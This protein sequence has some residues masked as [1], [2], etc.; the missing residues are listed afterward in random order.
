[1]CTK[2]ESKTILSLFRLGMNGIQ[3]GCTLCR[4][5]SDKVICLGEEQAFMIQL[6]I[7]D[8]LQWDIEDKKLHI[9]DEEFLNSSL[10]CDRRPVELSVLWDDQD[11]EAEIKDFI[12]SQQGIFK[13]WNKVCEPIVLTLAINSCNNVRDRDTLVHLCMN[14]Q[15]G[16]V[17]FRKIIM[18]I[19]NLLVVN[20]FD[21]NKQEYIAKFLQDFLEKLSDY[22]YRSDI[23]QNVES[24]SERLCDRI[25]G[26]NIDMLYREVKLQ[27]GDKKKR[28]EKEEDI[29]KYFAAL[30]GKDRIYFA[31]RLALI[32]QIF[33]KKNLD[34]KL[35][36][37]DQLYKFNGRIEETKY[38]KKVS[39]VIN[40]IDKQ[41]V[42][43]KQEAVERLSKMID[44]CVMDWIDEE[45]KSVHKW[46]LAG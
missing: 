36:L 40:T 38:T 3:K 24:R 9:L 45:V 28:K 18:K 15:Y 31:S 16:A 17:L 46:V 26:S 8:D 19:L 44:L 42:N 6:L 1:M 4:R 10:R 35:W 27:D 14:S 22:E 5:Q 43:R 37:P 13:H 33:T 23:E 41:D 2:D 11:E 29:L 7:A 30:D 25:K 20:W 12:Q 21:Q 32:Q 34:K 39:E